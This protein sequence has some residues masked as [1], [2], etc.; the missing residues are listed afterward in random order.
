MIKTLTIFQFYRA[1][2][3]SFPPKAHGEPLSKPIFRHIGH[4][5]GIAQL[6]GNMYTH[7]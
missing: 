4:T 6:K 1:V 2:T 5:V 7:F 3:N